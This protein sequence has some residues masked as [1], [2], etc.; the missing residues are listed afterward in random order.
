MIHALATAV[1]MFG[2][3]PAAWLLW[4]AERTIRTGEDPS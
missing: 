2:V 3:L 4:L 1:V